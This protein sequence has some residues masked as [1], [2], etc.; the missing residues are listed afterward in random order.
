MANRKPVPRTGRPNLPR[1][2]DPSSDLAWGCK[3][4]SEIINRS[5]VHTYRRHKLGLLPTRNVGALI[6]GRKSLLSDPASWP[7]G[8]RRNDP[9]D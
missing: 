6:V 9:H 2:D 3:A 7:R 1:V 8:Q 5:P 4:I